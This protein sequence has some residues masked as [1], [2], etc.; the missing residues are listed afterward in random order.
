M[1]ITYTT[2][3]TKRPTN[4]QA[5][6]LLTSRFIGVLKNWWDNYIQKDKR[7]KIK[8][9]INSQGQYRSINLYNCY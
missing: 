3:T 2:Y 9:H 1:L 8:N 5:F 6:D 7:N 4:L